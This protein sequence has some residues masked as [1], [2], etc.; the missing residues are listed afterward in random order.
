MH[1]D[2]ADRSDLRQLVA[3]LVE[4]H[5]DYAW[6]Q[7]A[8]TG[9]NRVAR[10]TV[11]FESELD[12]L[13]FPYGVVT[14]SASCES[15][16]VWLPRDASDHLTAGERAERDRLDDE[17]FGNRRKVIEQ[18]D[19]LVGLAPCPHADWHLATMGTVPARQRQGLGSA[20]LKPMLDR[21][22]AGQQ[23]ARLETSTTKNVEFYR[24][25]GFQVVDQLELPHGAPTTWI[26]HRPPKADW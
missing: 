16:A 25:H 14:K 23:S 18:V 10:L 17:V 7:W 26:M 13:A 12:M 2:R 21:L 1:T 22:D 15:V 5:L 24:S 8:V 9:A 19:E 4:S 6:E 11:A 3:T 20:V